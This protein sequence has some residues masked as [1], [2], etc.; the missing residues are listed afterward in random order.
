MKNNNAVSMLVQIILV[1]FDIVF[2]IMGLFYKELFIICE[3]I[4]GLTMFVLAFNNQ[5][6]YKRKYMTYI[7]AFLGIVILARALF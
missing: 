3:I 7:Y 4:T 5:K 2:L 6:I 1:L